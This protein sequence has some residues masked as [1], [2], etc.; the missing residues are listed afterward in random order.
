MKSWMLLL[1]IGAVQTL[2]S[3]KTFGS[4]AWPVM[5]YQPFS[6]PN[7]IEPSPVSYIGYYM[8][9]DAVAMTCW[10]NR[11]WHPEASKVYQENAAFAAGFKVSMD[12][13]DW[14]DRADTLRA[15]LDVTRL[16]SYRDRNGWR[17]TT[18]VAA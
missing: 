18:V 3:T 10:A 17:D 4:D 13:V 1:A 6:L 8:P 16:L 11:I 12:S 9:P 15:D 2:A 7:G 5:V 14:P